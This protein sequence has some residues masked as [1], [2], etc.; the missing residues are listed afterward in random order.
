MLDNI[1]IDAHL[2][3]DCLREYNFWG[4]KNIVNICTD[5]MHSIPWGLE[6]YFVAAITIAGIIVLCKIAWDIFSA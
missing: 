3:K 5:Q 1:N 4:K 2:I 6:D